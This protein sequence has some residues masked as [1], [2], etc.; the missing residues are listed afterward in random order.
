MD[1]PAKCQVGDKV[2]V[3]IGSIWHPCTVVKVGRWSHSS[4]NS[5]PVYTVEFTDG[6]QINCG[7]NSI[8]PARARR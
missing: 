4:S 5:F 6:S 3:M 1:E 8:R 7:N 2:K